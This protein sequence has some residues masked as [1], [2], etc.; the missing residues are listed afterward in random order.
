MSKKKLVK[1]DYNREFILFSILTLLSLSIIYLIFSLL[2]V[3]ELI[4][5]DYDKAAGPSLSLFL[6][7]SISSIGS[8]I[9]S[10]IILEKLFDINQLRNEWIITSLL[11][12][13]MI[14]YSVL[15]I[16]FK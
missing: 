4:G 15:P 8:W 12:V 7:K 14:G 6:I 9:I 2:N 1:H 5:F 10:M 11:I 13:I 16:L 3:T